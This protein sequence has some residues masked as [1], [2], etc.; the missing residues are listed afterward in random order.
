[1]PHPQDGSSLSH[2]HRVQLTFEVIEPKIHFFKDPVQG[3]PFTLPRNYVLVDEPSGIPNYAISNVQDWYRTFDPVFIVTIFLNNQE[4]FFSE[5]DSYHTV[6]VIDQLRPDLISYRFY[7]TVDYFW[8]IL[9]ANDILDP[10]N[11][12]QNTILRIP[13][14]TTVLNKWLVKPVTRIRGTL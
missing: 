6:T 3:R 12:R 8:I 11:M 9:L 5:N 14:T 1:M 13:S 10:F 4:N 7:G 2:S